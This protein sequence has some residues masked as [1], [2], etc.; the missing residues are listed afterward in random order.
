MDVEKSDFVYA[1]LAI[2]FVCVFTMIFFICMLDRRYKKYAYLFDKRNVEMRDFSVEVRNMPPDRLYGGKRLQLEALLWEHFE[3]RVKEA[4]EATSKDNQEEL[5]RIRRD[6]LYEIV[7]INFGYKSHREAAILTEMD[8]VD[9]EKNTIIHEA[10]VKFNDQEF[11]EDIEKKIRKCY[12]KYN[13][14]K[15]EYV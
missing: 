8:A 6:K 14:L 3:S 4:M 2:D 13:E 7:D 10:Q 5:E 1:I 12:E 9:R 11:P 15:A